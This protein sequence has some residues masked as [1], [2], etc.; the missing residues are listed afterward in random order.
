VVV[1]RA[2]PGLLLVAGLGTSLLALFV[3]AVELTL[4]VLE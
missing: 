2:H 3:D 1:G 4:N